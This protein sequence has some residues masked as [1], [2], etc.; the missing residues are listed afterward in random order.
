MLTE[1]VLVVVCVLRLF[2]FVPWV[3]L[4]YLLVTSLAVLLQAHSVMLALMTFLFTIIFTKNKEV[5]LTL[6]FTAIHVFY[7]IYLHI[8]IE[9]EYS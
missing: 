8:P 3:G 5:I 2:F 1:T 6:Y 7:C 4:R 9:S